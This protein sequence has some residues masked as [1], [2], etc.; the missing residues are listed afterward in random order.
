VSEQVSDSTSKYVNKDFGNLGK[1]P[2]PRFPGPSKI[3]LYFCRKCTLSEKMNVFHPKSQGPSAENRQTSHQK[4]VTE[5]EIETQLTN[6][7]G[8]R[9]VE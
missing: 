9:L 8:Q 5:K 1:M 4:K 2:V 6:I 3:K 7:E